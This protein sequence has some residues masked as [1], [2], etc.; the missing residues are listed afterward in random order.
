MVALAGISASTGKETKPLFWHVG[1]KFS[2]REK[3]GLGSGKTAPKHAQRGTAWFFNLR[4]KAL[5][6]DKKTPGKQVSPELPSGKTR[7]ELDKG[8]T[9]NALFQALRDHNNPVADKIRQRL[10]QLLPDNVQ[11]QVFA[12]YLDMIE[13]TARMPTSGGS[14]DPAG[15]VKDL[16]E[17][18]GKA[19]TQISKALRDMKKHIVEKGRR[20]STLL[21]LIDSLVS[22]EDLGY[23]RRY[24]SA[25][26][27]SCLAFWDKEEDAFLDEALAGEKVIDAGPFQ[28]TFQNF[29]SAPS[30]GHRFAESD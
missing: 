29:P 1:E 23:G 27:Y 17:E 15:V 18:T 4:A 19:P 8:E 21:K 20:D 28:L 10:R 24:A 30:G 7:Q 6:R 13:G 12:R 2:S 14:A 3:E 5:I 11:G 16:A 22:T 25:A 26:A 9:S